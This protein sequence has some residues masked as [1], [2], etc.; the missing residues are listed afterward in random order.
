VRPTTS[1]TVRLRIRDRKTLNSGGILPL[2]LGVP[3]AL[4]LLTLGVRRRRRAA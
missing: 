2:A 1:P 3:A 4:G